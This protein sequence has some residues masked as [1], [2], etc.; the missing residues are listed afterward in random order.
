M[1]L[2]ANATSGED[3]TKAQTA[4]GEPDE[5]AEPS[6]R[7]VLPP[8]VEDELDE[9]DDLEERDDLDEPDER[10]DPEP[11]EREAAEEQKAEPVM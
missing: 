8:A 1:R 2:E 6:L 7:E 4:E 11:S 3:G 10:E 9:R 5:L